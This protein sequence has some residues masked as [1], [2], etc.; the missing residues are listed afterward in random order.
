MKSYFQ[1]IPLLKDFAKKNGKSI[2]N[3]ESVN[4][5]WGDAFRKYLKIEKNHNVNNADK[6]I[7]NVKSLMNYSLKLELHGNTKF[8]FITREKDVT[9]EIYLKEEQI[10][11]MYL[12]EVSEEFQ[13]T[14]DVFVFSCLTGQRISDILKLESHNWKGD[15]IEIQTEKTEEKLLIPLRKTAKEILEKYKGKL[16]KVYEQKYN[17][18][19]KYIA[20]LI[21]S[22]HES[23]IIYTTKGGERKQTTACMYELVKSHTARRSFATNEYKAGVDPLFIRAV[24]G[25]KTEKDFFNY[26]KVAQKEKVQTLKNIFDGRDF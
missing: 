9:T 4:S 22:L 12:L 18:Q 24:T 1:L 10:K 8:E 2:L 26:I 13:H 25:H 11:E 7:K 6:H 5:T 23:E 20:E 3:F 21:P 14:K 19:L 17:K 16:P 15:Y